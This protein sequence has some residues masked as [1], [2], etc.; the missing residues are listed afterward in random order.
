MTK[1]LIYH[2]IFSVIIFII[3]FCIK[4]FRKKAFFIFLITFLIPIIGFIY[5]LSNIVLKDFIKSSKNILDSY[6]EYINKYNNPKKIIHAIDFK[7]EINLVATS[8][9]MDL[10]K[11]SIKRELIIDVLKGDYFEH[12]KV[13]KKALKNEDTETSHYAAAGITQIKKYFEEELITKRNNYLEK[14]DVDSL[15]EYLELVKS[16]IKS[17]LLDEINHE[18]FNAI[19]SN[20]LEELLYEHIENPE[21][22]IEKINIELSYNNFKKAKKYCIQFSAYFPND[23]RPYIMFMKLYY[24]ITDY[25]N[26]NNVLG[27]LMENSNVTLSNEGLNKVRFWR[28]ELS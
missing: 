8:E 6:D 1:L 15:I 20:L 27:N 2:I 22:Y 25:E 5:I 7:K 3:F 24:V 28:G 14:K 17:E 18:K 26:F 9:A 10:N 12:I 13:L 4:S 21:F 11:D 16:Y 23:E 19:Y